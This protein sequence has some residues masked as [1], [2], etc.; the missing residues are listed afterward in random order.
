MKNTLP[1]KC[2]CGETWNTLRE[3]VDDERTDYRGVLESS[4]MAALIFN[5]D[6]CRTSLGIDE[7]FFSYLTKK[8][9]FIPCFNNGGKK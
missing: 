1:L 5:V 9:G 7:R 4:K 6:C 3:F 8:E 2:T